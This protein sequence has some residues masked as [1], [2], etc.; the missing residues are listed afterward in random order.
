MN[1]TD[2]NNI[3]EVIGY[4]PEDDESFFGL[5]QQAFIRSS[6]SK[7]NGGQ[8]NEVLEFIGD[9]A[10]DLAVIKILTEYYD[11]Q[12]NEDNEFELQDN[13]NEGKLTA[14]KQKFVSRDML[15]RRIDMIGFQDYL[16]MGNGDINKKVQNEDSV[17]EDLFEAIIGAITIDC[18]WNINVIQD[19]VENMLGVTYCLECGYDD[20]RNFID[21]LQQWCQ[22]KF[23]ELPRYESESG[24]KYYNGEYDYSN[25]DNKE[26]HC[27]VYIPHMDWMRFD[28]NGHTKSE[29]KMCAAYEAYKYIED[30]EMPNYLHDTIGEISEE[31]A[32][33][34]LQELAQKGFC[35]MPEYIFEES[36]DN[37]GNPI[38]HCECHICNQE[39]SF[40]FDSSSKKEAKRKVAYKMLNYVIKSFK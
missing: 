13:I 29:A 24:E 19:V 3:L 7:E 39:K 28:G 33:N 8:N 12:I 18:C 36:H 37:N 1:W 26:Y 14:L 23:G 34:Q 21:L 9:K 25:E 10:L 32:I 38:W 30:G 35:K 31:K 27:N 2:Y 20:A 11:G 6:Y 22:K 4:E 16:I 5:L 17:K 15:A 40:K